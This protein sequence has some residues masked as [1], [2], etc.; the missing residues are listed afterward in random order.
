MGLCGW[1]RRGYLTAPLW[2]INHGLWTFLRLPAVAMY[3]IAGCVAL[4]SSVGAMGS[5]ATGVYLWCCVPYIG[6]F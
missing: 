5:S 2:T 6:W 1:L 3:G 4:R